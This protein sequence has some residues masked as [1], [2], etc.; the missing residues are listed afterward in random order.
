MKKLNILFD[1]YVLAECDNTGASRSGIFFTA[2][3]ILKEFSKNENINI[4]IYCSNKKFSKKLEKALKK[5]I[6]HGLAQNIDNTWILTET[7]FLVSN[8]ILSDVLS[9]I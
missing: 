6:A 1:A 7:G 8:A 5:Y 2:L 9:S 4:S 3:N